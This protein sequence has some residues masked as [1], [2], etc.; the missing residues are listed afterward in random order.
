M[1][2]FHIIEIAG[3]CVFAISGILATRGKRLDLLGAGTIAVVTA[4]GGGTLRDVLLDHRPLFWMQDPTYLVVILASAAA[5]FLYTR[6]FVPPDKALLV[7]DALGLA[8]FT[9]GGAHIAERDHFHAVII[10]LMGTVT[11]VAG[12]VIRDVLLAEI[13]MVFRQGSLYATA[14]IL[15]VILYLAAQ[16]MGC[17]QLLA[18][19]L[20]MSAIFII[21][22]AAMIWKISL[23]EFFHSRN[24]L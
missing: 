19:I 9:I 15:G 3:V 16:S 11:G 10:I 12:G 1:K 6:F 14:S 17:T 18:S 13:P 22:L 23:P 21:R 5:T 20:G 4:I 8:F 7:A 2:I 24:R